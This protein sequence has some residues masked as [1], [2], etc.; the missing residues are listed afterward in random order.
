M[1][2][3]AEDGGAD[4]LLDVLAHP[5][6]TATAHER[7]VGFG[8]NQMQKLSCEKGG[9][10]SPVVFLLKVAD[11]D[12]ARAAAHGE[13]VLLRRPLDAASG[14]VDPEDDQGGLPCAVPQGP[15]VG[16]TVRA[17][18]HYA[19]T[20]CG[21]VDTCRG[22]ETLCSYYLSKSFCFVYKVYYPE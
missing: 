7:S 15:H 6:F 9:G 20:V 12:E 13:L 2:V 11:G 3:Q 19:V 22:E 16:V 8:N 1:P 10:T 18:G 5:P 21:P 17:A 14:A 4:G